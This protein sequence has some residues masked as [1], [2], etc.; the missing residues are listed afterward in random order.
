M[1]VP[2]K[3]DLAIFI[4]YIKLKMEPMRKERGSFG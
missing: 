2:D 4:K 3:D 1:V